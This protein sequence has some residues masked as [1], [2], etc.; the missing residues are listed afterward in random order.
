MLVVTRRV[1]EIITIQL[2]KDIDPEIS[3]RQL[4]ADGPIELVVKHIHGMQC[5]LGIVAGPQFRIL[6]QKLQET[7]P[8][9]IK[10]G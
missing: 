3:A 8:S 1:G 4:F 6:R 2:A 10:K 9:I 5:K 7:V